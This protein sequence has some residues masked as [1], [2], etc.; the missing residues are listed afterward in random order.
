[1]IKQ[2]LNSYFIQAGVGMHCIILVG[3]RCSECLPEFDLF[4]LKNNECQPNAHYTDMHKTIVST[5][6]VYKKCLIT[7]NAIHRLRKTITSA[8]CIG[9]TLCLTCK[10]SF[11]ASIHFSGS[12][13]RESYF[14]ESF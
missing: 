14:F 7:S 3:C 13:Y 12:S 8:F 5:Q 6:Q 4:H 1:M 11:L 2:W 9:A 10:A